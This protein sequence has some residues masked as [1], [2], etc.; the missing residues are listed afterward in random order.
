MLGLGNT[1]SGGIVPAVAVYPNTYSVD[2]DSTDDYITMGDNNIFSFGDA[3]T[4]SAFSVV[5]WV[6]MDDATK[7]RVL[8]KS[9]AATTTVE[10]FVGTEA[11]DKFSLYLYDNNTGVQ[12]RASTV[13]LTSN[14][15]TWI[16]V[17]CTYDGGGANTGIHLYIN[18]EDA[19]DS[20]GVGGGGD[21]VAMH[22]TTAGLEIGRLANASATTYSD[23]TIDEVSLW[24]KELSVGEVAAIWNNGLLT[25]LSDESGLIG[26]WRM[27]EGTGTT[28]A[29]GSSNSNTGTL[30][31]SPAWS[32]DTP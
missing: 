16:H 26:W 10:W 2:F 31:N 21:Y 25:D 30:T 7:F 18:G 32:S 24:D 3:S 9:A 20:V 28:V 4:D 22:N 13:A 14:E 1:L 19:D 17:A 23:G 8:S 5:A 27:E 12:I 29:D 15:N 11:N 6:K